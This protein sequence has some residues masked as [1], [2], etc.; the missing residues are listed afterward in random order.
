MSEPSVMSDVSQ[1]SDQ[2]PRNEYPVRAIGEV[3]L[4]VV[5]AQGSGS[6]PMFVGGC[7][8]NERATRALVVLHGRLRDADAYLRSTLRARAASSAHD[9]DTLVVVPQFLASADVEHHRAPAHLLHWEWTAW[10]GGADARGPAPLSSFDA[11]DA[12]VAQLADRARYPALCEIVIAGH[13]GGAQVAHRYAILSAAPERCAQRGVTLRFV[14]ANPSS[15]VYFDS[16]R[17]QPDGGFAPAGHTACPDVDDWKYGMRKLPRYAAAMHD[18][19]TLERRYL[20]REVVY[21]AGERDCDP[22]HPALDRSCAASAQGPHRLARARAYFAYLGA[23]HPQ[24]RHTWFEVPGAGHNAE[25]MFLSGPGIRALFG[26]RA[27][28]DAARAASQAPGAGGAD[29]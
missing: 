9:D 11:L 23:R 17:P 28:I 7:T 14:I 24:L 22:V 18:A 13:S 20:E 2:R 10:M 26:A 21:L 4:R 15:W 29:D 3:M 5:T 19:A 6:V 16:L 12:L 8:A 1:A 25:A 27:T